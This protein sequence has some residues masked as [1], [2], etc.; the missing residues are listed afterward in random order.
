M[1]AQALHLLGHLRLEHTRPS[2]LFEY[3]HHVIARKDD[4][5]FWKSVHTMASE[6]PLAAIAFGLST[7]LASIL[8]GSFTSPD[9]DE[10]TVDVLPPKVRQWADC[11]GRRAVLADVPG[12]KLY[13]LLEDA[14]QGHDVQPQSTGL[15]RL[16]PLRRIDR[17]MQP[18]EREG[19]RARLSREAIEFRF[20]L[21]RLRFHLQQGIRLAMEVRRWKRLSALDRDSRPSSFSRYVP[22]RD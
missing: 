11:Y 7:L 14:L 19:L 21:F 17:I 12:S 10:W 4:H 18:P 2:W 15:R 8:F 6:T 20:L 3:R 22:R 1:I 9:F 13:L 16:I 5:D